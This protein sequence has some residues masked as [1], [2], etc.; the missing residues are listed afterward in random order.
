MLRRIWITLVV[1]T[2]FYTVVIVAG[3]RAPH[4]PSFS[5]L[6]FAAPALVVAVLSVLLPPRLLANALAS[7][8]VAGEQTLFDA[9]PKFQSAVLTG[10]ALAEAVA[11]FG[12]MAAYSGAP[13]S[14]WA[15]FFAFAF[16]FM[17]VHFPRIETL[18]RALERKTGKTFKV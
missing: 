12:L 5:P 13:P 17:A 9:F 1:S 15:P 4:R 11:L 10:T 6:A 3:A 7:V 16:A 14:I 8:E 18:V 2:G